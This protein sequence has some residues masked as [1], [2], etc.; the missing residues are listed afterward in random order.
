MTPLTNEQ[1]KR[2]TAALTETYQMLS[3]ELSKSSRLQSQERIG[4]LNKHIVKLETMLN[5][6]EWEGAWTN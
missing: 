4:S 2:A 3:K 5:T 6:K 1:I